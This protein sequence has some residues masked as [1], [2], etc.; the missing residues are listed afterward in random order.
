MKKC[1]TLLGTRRGPIEATGRD[2]DTP[3]RMDRIQRTENTSVDG[4][5]EHEK[6]EKLEPVKWYNHFR[7]QCAPATP[8]QASA[9]EKRKPVRTRTRTGVSA[10]TPLTT[11]KMETTQML[12][13]WCMDQVAFPTQWNRTQNKQRPL[14]TQ[15]TRM[16]LQNRPTEGSQ[17]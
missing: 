12:V 16:S 17:I 9:Q 5:L 8:P 7:K 15:T 10:A 1:S 4:V 13:S 11:A 6:L 14:D 2:Y 3:A